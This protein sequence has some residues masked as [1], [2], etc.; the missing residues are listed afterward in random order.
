LADEAGWTLPGAVA[1]TSADLAPAFHDDPPSFGSDALVRLSETRLTL[2]AAPDQARRWADLLAA[3]ADVLRVAISGP[4]CV[5]EAHHGRRWTHRAL[6]L[7]RSNRIGGVGVVD[8]AA[9][10]P[11]LWLHADPAL[12]QIT[13]DEMLAPLE[14]LTPHLR[15]VQAT[16]LLK[17]LQAR[18][19]APALAR[20]MGNHHNTIRRRL[21]SLHE[22][23]GDRLSDPEQTLPLLGCL[24]ILLPQWR[25]ADTSGRPGYRPGDGAP[26]AT[27]GA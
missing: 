12:A 8:C 4:M 13:A 25:E 26:A 20:R 11:T 23:L 1:V 15:V 18:E 9:H 16:T 10:R 7:T 22:L 3:R 2:V 6:D 17:W 24:E 5:E 14:R 19:S 21:A 27:G